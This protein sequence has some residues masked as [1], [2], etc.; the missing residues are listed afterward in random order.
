MMKRWVGVLFT[1]ILAA[2]G[3]T[4]SSEAQQ[5]RAKLYSQPVPPP[6]EL[7]DRL[8]LKMNFRVYVPMDGRHDGL[9]TVQLHGT[10]LF[11]QTRSGLVTLIDAETGAALWRQRVGR[12]YV[13]EHRLAFNSREVYVVNNV[14]LYALDR[15]TGAENWHYRLPEAVAAAPV[16]DENM[17]F[18]PS[19]T[20][21][22]M[23]YL[24]PRPDLLSAEEKL[25][26]GKQE[27]REQRFQRIA[28]LRTDTGGSSSTVSHLTAS[29]R[30]A[31]T[32][33][34]DRQPT[35][36]RVWSEMTNLRLELPIVITRDRLVIPT[37]NGTVIGLGKLPM[38][39]GAATLSYRFSAESPIR[40]A[41]G[42]ID[43]VAYVGGEDAN[44]YALETSGG[45]LRWRYTA[46]VPI[47]RQPAAIEE[48]V[49]IVAARQGMTRLDRATGQPVWRIPGRGGLSESNAAADHFLAANPKYV[50]ALDASGRFLV[51][52]RRRGVT[53]SGFD[54]RDFVFPISNDVTDR[55]Y[56]AANNG[57]IVCLRD[58]QYPKAIRHRQREEDA[59]NPIRLRLADLINDP[60]TP[61]MLLSD[62]L[63]MW[64]KRYPPLRF[65]FEE[66][67]FRDAE[68]EP[69]GG[70]NVK[71]PAVKDKALGDVLK[72]MLAPLKCT[73]EIVGD[74]ILI[75]P[76]AA[77]R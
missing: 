26:A 27:T 22:I 42:Y 30:E 39:N 69:P 64:T 23:A 34:D 46:G 45:R 58:R 10:T 73:Y 57:L 36:T 70:L 75:L 1:A 15:L 16:A 77:L 37:P 24:L 12:A 29:A 65:R 53:L 9:A 19:Q 41:A 51:L 76:L 50:Y 35:P 21:R 62:M 2:I 4:T 17:I 56:L 61:P 7:L 25:A 3:L 8:N 49:Y 60:G 33:E 55:I 44:V 31:S 54:S 71:M 74:T 66:G 47:S 20:G 48:D 5:T 18:V 67:A 52:E 6:R 38:A 32:A 11:V 68:R 43:G 40:E 28:S 63:A 72:D 13:S 59:E 14:Y